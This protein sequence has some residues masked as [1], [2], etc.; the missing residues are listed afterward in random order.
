MAI[1]AAMRQ[2]ASARA[3]VAQRTAGAS[4]ESAARLETA[5]RTLQDA[6]APLQGLLDALQEADLKPT[7]AVEAAATEAIKKADAAIAA[8]KGGNEPQVLREQR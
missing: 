2:L 1:D 3:D 7:P 8:Y 6:F 4:G 5:A